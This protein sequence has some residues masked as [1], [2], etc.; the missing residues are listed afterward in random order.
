M[1][2]D[3]EA[4]NAPIAE[5]EKVTSYCHFGGYL[6]QLDYVGAFELSTEQI[7]IIFW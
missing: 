6:R 1:T 7:F 5:E 2:E 4:Q 3:V